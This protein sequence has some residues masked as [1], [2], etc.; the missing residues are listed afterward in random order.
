M[1]LVKFIWS[2]HKYS[3][4]KI[5]N[6]VAVILAFTPYLLKVKTKFTF[7]IVKLAK[8]KV[9]LC[10]KLSWMAALLQCDVISFKGGAH[11]FVYFQYGNALSII[12]SL[13]VFSSLFDAS[14]EIYYPIQFFSKWVCLAGSLAQAY[15]HTVIWAYT[16][17]LLHTP[18]MY[19][20]SV[21][22]CLCQRA[23]EA[24]SF[25]ETFN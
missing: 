6:Y 8:K 20:N 19:I 21:Q 24:H 5:P 13:H 9:P 18:N 4:N 2:V 3:C 10:P 11:G 14:T 22:T 17:M 12:V 7:S 15:L 23:S 16:C 25:R 1:T